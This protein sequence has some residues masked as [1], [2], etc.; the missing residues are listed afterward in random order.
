M[1][2]GVADQA[3][4]FV[5]GVHEARANATARRSA[6]LE[7]RIIMHGPLT[8]SAADKADAARGAA[9]LEDLSVFAAG[10]ALVMRDRRVLA[11]GA[12]EPASAVIT[13]IA[14]LTLRTRKRRG[15]AVIHA[16]ETIDQALMQAVLGAQLAGVAVVSLSGD[17]AGKSAVAHAG[18]AGA[19]GLFYATVVEQTGQRHD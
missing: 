12:S 10:T 17:E 16:S 7:R 19:L 3:G 15:V 5:A 2:I 11:I 4:L 14:A 6:K 18:M 9:I 1:M 13:R 8:A